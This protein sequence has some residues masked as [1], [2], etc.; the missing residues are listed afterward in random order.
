MAIFLLYIYIPQQFRQMLLKTVNKTS[1]L[2]SCMMFDTGCIFQIATFLWSA[3]LRVI[4]CD[5]VLLRPLPDHLG[6]LKCAEQ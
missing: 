6:P 4:C 2:I 1:R 3:V 5:F